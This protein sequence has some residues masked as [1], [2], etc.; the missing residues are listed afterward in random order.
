MQQSGYCTWFRSR[1]KI[2]MHIV[3]KGCNHYRHRTVTDVKT[4]AIVSKIVEVFD[5]EIVN[6]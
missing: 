1:K 4:D 6:A 2:P 3:D 5:G